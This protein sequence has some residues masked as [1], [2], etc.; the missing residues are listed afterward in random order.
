MDLR[1]QKLS[2]VLLDRVRQFIL[3]RKVYYQPFVFSE[4]LEVGEGLAFRKRL[5][6]HSRKPGVY[7]PSGPEALDELLVRPDEL[8]E[9]RSANADLREVYDY[10]VDFLASQ[11][12]DDLPQTEFGEFGCNTGYFL[13]RLSLRGAKRCIGY[14][15][16]DNTDVFAWFREAIGSRAE[17][18]RAEWDGL[19]HGARL[20]RVPQV[21]VFLSIAVTC[22]LPD[23]VQHLAWLCDRSRRAV[24]LWV[25]HNYRDDLSLDFGQPGHF[26]G[27][28]AFPLSFDNEMRPSR[29]LVERTLQECGFTRIIEMPRPD[30]LGKLTNW[31]G[32]Q[33]GLLAFRT[34]EPQTVYSGGRTRRVTGGRDEFPGSTR[35]PVNPEDP[36]RLIF[37]GERINIVYFAGLYYAIPKSAG[38]VDLRDDAQRE[39][40][41]SAHCVDLLLDFVETET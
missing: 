24:F 9:F 20:V 31:W 34:Y 6:D 25:P 11:L 32:S 19:L 35:R 41:V 39:Q 8:A 37:P 36:P 30:G 10:F 13:H 16:T 3:Q 23:P 17:F 38:A 14:D 15:Q 33:L 5:F 7:W 22:H 29:K 1:A 26:P 21:D 12:G 28:L 2:P 4:D 18:A 40:L 27:H